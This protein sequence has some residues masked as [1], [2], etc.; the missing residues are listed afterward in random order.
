MSQDDLSDSVY[1]EMFPP[2]DGWV[3]LVGPG[4]HLH[5]VPSLTDSFEAGGAL[6]VLRGFKWRKE[7]LLTASDAQDL[8]RRL[9]ELAA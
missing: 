4:W 8:A 9:L 6:V 7:F 3:M 1:E 5:V 2:R